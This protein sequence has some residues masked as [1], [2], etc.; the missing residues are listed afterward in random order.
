MEELNEPCEA[1]MEE[2]LTLEREMSHYG[3]KRFNDKLEEAKRMERESSTP[4]GISLLKGAIEP[5]AKGIDNEMKK[6]KSGQA[7]IHG[8]LFLGLE[9]HDS[10]VMAYLTIKALLDSISRSEPLNTMAI[11]V[12]RAIEDDLMLASF[13]KQ[14]RPLID[15]VK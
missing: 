2:Q 8:R 10:K 5:I 7:W 4:A 1:L 9:K 14:N 6:I 11:K 15:K 3:V 13:V 12:G